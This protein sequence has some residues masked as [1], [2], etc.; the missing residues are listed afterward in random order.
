MLLT[1]EAILQ[2]VDLP[3]E[4]VSVPEWGGDVLVRAL[5]GAERDQFEA[6]IIDQKG[7]GT[8]INHKNMRAKLV[9]LTIVDESGN[10]LFADDDVVALGRKSAAGLNRVFSA[11]QRLSGLTQEDVDELEKNS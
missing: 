4:Q 10:R 2:A 5:T 6:S 7:K 9:A 3:K 1:R 11:A 8:R